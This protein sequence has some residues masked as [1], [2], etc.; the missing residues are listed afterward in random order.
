MATTSLIRGKA[1]MKTAAMKAQ[2]MDT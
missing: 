1:V 2:P